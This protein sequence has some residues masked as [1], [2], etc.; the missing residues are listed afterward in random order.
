M[1]LNQFQFIQQYQSSVAG[2]I[3]G[4]VK[5]TATVAKSRGG[6][7]TFQLTSLNA[8]VSGQ[9]VEID[10]KAVGTVHVTASTEGAMLAAHLESKIANSA[11]H[12]DGH[13][14][15]TDDYPGSA[16]FT[17][18]K[19]DLAALQSWLARPAS[20]FQL[21]GSVE[22][23]ATISG[24]AFKP[25]A[26]T[27]TLEMPQLEISPLPGDIAGGNR[28]AIT[29]RN[30]GP[31]RL[32]MQ[33]GVIRVESARLIAQDT[34]VA[35]T[36]TISLKEKN[37]LDL[38]VNGDINLTLL[39]NF[40]PDVVSSGKLIADATVRG[41]LMQPSVTGRAELQNANLSLATFPSGI[42]NANGMVLFNG[43]RATIQNL[44]GESG[45]G[46]VSVTG[47]AS[48]SAGDT[49]FRFELTANE[50][51]VRYPEGVS[52]VADAKL[53]WTG[54]MQRSLVSGTVTILRS[55]FNTRTDIGSILAK[56][57]E[58]VRTP[59]ARTGFLGGMNFDIQIDTSPNVQVQA[60]LAQ[61]IQAEASLHLRGT[62]SNPA[63]L[64][65]VNITQGE[66]TFFG[67]KYTINQGSI[68]FFNP[69]KVEPILNVD[70][71]T[72]A[73]GIDVTLTIS[74]PM[75]KLNVS[76]RSDPPMQFSDI[77][78]LLAT[79]RTPSSDLSLAARQSGAAQ[80]WQQMGASALVGQAIANPVAGRL[81]RFFGVS[82]I[83]IDPQL[84]GIENPQARLTLE[85]QITPDITFTYITN[86]TRSNPQVIRIEWAVNRRWSVVALRDE[87]GV[88][89]VDFYYKRRF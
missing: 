27:A 67:N 7:A 26:W 45:G 64:G 12:G 51:R 48:Y 80:S 57:A 49:T 1:A 36:G 16:Q 8:D 82:R 85:Q 21:T 28:R 4:T 14:Q 43:D 69:V 75:N 9:G 63:L 31:V 13:W 58:P 87:T 54:T 42:S 25:D 2:N 6:Q 84:T 52:T 32:T 56:S 77:V 30:Q 55:G 66:L 47:F 68:S 44:T 3:Q 50:M 83:K 38:R 24:P 70:L 73:R 62:M 65:R 34:N 39:E 88:F 15:L 76:Y 40:N 5:G 18:T 86:V 41:P 23:K 72:R 78:A 35:L 53:T 46:K 17:F 79:G 11:I 61:Q 60:A 37:P 10:H 19:L 59:A 33:N 74:G 22:G 71:Q 89:G 20:S 29:L 81:Q